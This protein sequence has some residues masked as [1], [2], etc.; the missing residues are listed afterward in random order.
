MIGTDFGNYR[1]EQKL[2]EGGMGVVYL[3]V[4]KNLDRRVALKMLA[5]G[6]SQDGEIVSRFL[7]EA[8]AASR[9][10][11]PAIVTMYHFGLEG[12]TRYMVMEYVEG[13]TLRKVIAGKP[14]GI[15]QAVEFAIQIAD[16]LVTA[17][18][19]GVVHRDLKADNIMVTPRGQVKI[20]DFGLAKL[21]SKQVS[22]DDET[23][24]RTQFGMV[25]GTVTTMS[26]E[27]AIGKEVDASS[28]VFSFGVV[29]YQ[30]ATG[31]LPFEGPTPQATLALILNQE[32]TPSC[33]LNPD[34]PPELDRLIQHCLQKGSVF[35]PSARELLGKLKNIQASLSGSK[36]MDAQ[37]RTADVPASAP[38]AAS[39]SRSLPATTTS[40]GS[41]KVASGVRP[42]FTFADIAARKACYYSLKSVRVV[43]SI[44]TLAVP[45]SYLAYFGISGGAVRAD[46]LEGTAAL[47][48]VQAMVTPALALSDKFLALH[49]QI[50]GWNFLLLGFAL[51]TFL[52][53]YPLLLPFT[54]AE[55]WAKTR[56]L[57][58]E[59]GSPQVVGMTATAGSSDSRLTLLREYAETRKALYEDKKRLAFYA[60]DV[61]GST[62]MKPGQDQLVVEHAFA[63]FKKYVER[64]LD[65]NG[66]WKSS[67]TPDGAMCAFPD[68]RAAV[69]AAQ[70][71]LRGLDW[72]NAGVHILSH[73]FRLRSGVHC[74]EV[75]FPDDKNIVEISNFVIDVAGHLQKHSEENALWIS[76]DVMDALQDVDGFS[77]VDEPVD[78]FKV[79][80]WRHQGKSKAAVNH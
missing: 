46:A 42:Q 13:K 27:Q 68:A 37:F 35:R 43:V 78:G 45:L 61:V 56:K 54:F 31:K 69:K 8:K 3:A 50:G 64:I 39:A 4:D 26:P 32:P 15:G 52:A 33:P 44:A 71:V 28:D 63:E 17:H 6:A 1:I 79:F 7:R 5:G 22:P 21:K 18:E 11:H 29:L 2:G 75:V 23:V 60:F 51:L 70:E 14:L 19:N 55:H 80:S 41:T 16:G 57:K 59:A 36:L 38:G 40:S 12:E 20:L 34:I 47:H 66:C 77:P 25:V 58:A 49:T 48:F 76:S 62:K 53:R 74:G 67:W 65:L 72:F 9:L 30:M 10:Q 73:T 24:F